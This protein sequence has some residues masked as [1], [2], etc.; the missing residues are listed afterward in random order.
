M[1]LVKRTGVSIVAALVAATMAVSGAYAN[2]DARFEVRRASTTLTD[3]V[4]FLNAELYYRLSPQAIEA[5]DNGVNLTVDVEIEILRSRRWRIDPEVAALK[6]SFQLAFNALSRRY[7]V[8]NLNSGAQRSYSS[9]NASLT[10]MGQIAELP[11][12]DA[13]LLDSEGRYI[14]RIR[15]VLDQQKLPGSLQLL[16]FWSDGYRLESDW[17]SWILSE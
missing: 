12:I 9:L 7:V 13:A 8:L 1:A 16:A 11:V 4:F 5:L 17:Y 10:A 15:S 2:D 14:I 3:N 6:Q